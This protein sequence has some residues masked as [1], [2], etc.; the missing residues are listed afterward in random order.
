MKFPITREYLQ[1][2]CPE[3]DMVEQREIA[4]E[5]HVNSLMNAICNKLKTSITNLPEYKGIDY[6]YKKEHDEIQKKILSEKRFIYNIEHINK[7]A[8][9]HLVVEANILIERLYHKLRQTFIACDI[10]IDP[11]NTYIMINWS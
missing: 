11:L 5:H 4:I 2:F 6:L 8:N 9:T 10:I 3:Q 1:T 7:N